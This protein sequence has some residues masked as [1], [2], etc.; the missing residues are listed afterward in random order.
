MSSVFHQLRKPFWARVIA[1]T[2]VASV[3]VALLLRALV[4]N[5][6][7]LD[8][9]FVLSFLLP[10]HWYVVLQTSGRLTMAILATW[11]VFIARRRIGRFVE[12]TPAGALRIVIAVVLALGASEL[13]LNRKHLRP[14]DWPPA[15]DEP[16]RQPT[17]QLCWTLVP[18]RT[19]HKSIG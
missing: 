18:P 4:A 9:H 12:R 14:A 19:G 3:G 6:G 10:R 13:A 8:R 2:A 15:E 7:F 16:L 5:Q 17:P 11:L 1:E